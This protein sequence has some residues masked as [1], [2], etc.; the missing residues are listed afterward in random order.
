[1]I[2]GMQTLVSL[3]PSDATMAATFPGIDQWITIGPAPASGDPFTT[4]LQVA[5]EKQILATLAVQP[6]GGGGS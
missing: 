2:N 6:A 3:D 1:V 4:E 5:V